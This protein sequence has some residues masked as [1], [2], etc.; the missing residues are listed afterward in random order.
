MTPAAARKNM[1]A[2]IRWPSLAL[3]PQR[4]ALQRLGEQH[5]LREDQV[6]AVVVGELVVVAHS[7]RVERAGDLAVAAEDAARQV[8]LVNGRVALARRDPV[9]GCVLLGDDPDAVRRAGGRAQRAA[10][11]LLEARVL[12]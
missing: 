8:D 2:L 5:L 4:R 3:V 11:A 9:L 7:D 6:R 10:D 12:E 1:T